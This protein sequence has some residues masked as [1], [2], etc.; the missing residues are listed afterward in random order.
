MSRRSGAREME[1]L[2]NAG[3]YRNDSILILQNAFDQQKRV[4]YHRGVI[5]FKE[6]RRD[7]DVG[8]AGFIFKAEKYK[9]FGRSRTLANDHGSSHANN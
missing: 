3:L 2:D 5:F 7:D 4:V 8:D 9:S 6:L 1:G